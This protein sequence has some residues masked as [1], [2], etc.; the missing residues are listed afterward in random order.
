MNWC[1]KK[2]AGWTTG[3]QVGE[4]MD[5]SAPHFP[6]LLNYSANNLNSWNFVFNEKKRFFLLGH[7]ATSSLSEQPRNSRDI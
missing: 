3:S 5:S 4:K 1:D 7:F 2:F 6:Q